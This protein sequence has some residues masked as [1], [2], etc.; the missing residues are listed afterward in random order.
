MA[1]LLLCL[2]QGLQAQPDPVPLAK[3]RDRE[4][5]PEIAPPKKPAPAAVYLKPDT[6]R[7][8]AGDERFKLFYLGEFRRQSWEKLRDSAHPNALWFNA[9][10][11][12]PTGS[13]F[14]DM[15]SDYV[16]NIKLNFAAMYTV[17]PEDTARS[18]HG[19]FNGGGN[20]G[21][22]ASMPLVFA[23]SR[24]AR[25][26]RYLGLCLAPRIGAWLPGLYGNRDLQIVKEA[27]MDLLFGL[28][29]DGRHMSFSG[30][31][32]T[33]W[34]FG[35]HTF[36]NRFGSEGTKYFAYELLTLS[37][38]I[39][40][41]SFSTRMPLRLWYRGEMYRNLPAFVSFGVNY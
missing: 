8:A 34:S 32:R 38:K 24:D 31:L 15:L 11:E 4:R 27:G 13:V 35:E 10:T 40:Q 41:Y 7:S 33:A 19:I 28:V 36:L 21:F 17:A 23:G 37:L 5:G 3:G 22:R 12:S 16:G 9:S 1:C 26:N 6:P 29:T 25:F 39:R 14:A 18:Y 20:L 2:G 30:S